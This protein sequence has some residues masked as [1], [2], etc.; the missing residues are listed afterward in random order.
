MDDAPVYYSPGEHRRTGMSGCTFALL[1]CGVVAL[2]LI[3]AIGI[4]VWYVTTNIRTIASNVL[5]SVVT[6]TVEQSKLP[7]DQ[8]AR[9]IARIGQVKEDFQAGLIT[10]Q[11]A[12]QVFDN[13]MES[14]LLPLG[15]VEF[16]EEQYIKPSELSEEEKQAA[17]RSLQRFARGVYE[18][19]IPREAIDHV[20]EPVSEKEPVADKEGDRG[21]ELKNKPTADELREM[22][23][24]AQQHA[25]EA[26]IADE[27]FQ[28]NVADELDRVI[29]AGLAG[30]SLKKKK[31]PKEEAKQEQVPI[32]EA[33]EQVEAPDQV[34]ATEQ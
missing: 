33:P 21:R 22:I 23:K 15:A 17:Y 30:K 3:V 27:P 6:S 34:E 13:L 19:K 5:S 14:P 18:D 4:G 10:D 7:D 25:D 24:R 12:E 31:D 29:D 16:Y 11:Q 26:K 32:V 2:L 9:I 1:G 8:K 20:L 28:V